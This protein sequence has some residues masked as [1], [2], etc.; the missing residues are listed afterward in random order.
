MKK[1]SDQGLS[2]DSTIRFFEKAPLGYLIL[3]KR[4]MILDVNDKLCQLLNYKKS[5]MISIQLFG[6]IYKEDQ[7][8][9]EDNYKSFFREPEGQKLKLRLLQ[10]D[11]TLFYAELV[12]SKDEI[13]SLKGKNRDVLLVNVIDNTKEQEQ[14]QEIKSNKR[15]FEVLFNQSVVGIATMKPDGTIIEL[16]ERFAG[17]IG[18]QQEELTGR[19]FREITYEKDMKLEEQYLSEVIAGERNSFE[20]EK[21]YIHKDGHLVWIKLYSN[22]VRDNSGNSLYAIASITDISQEKQREGQREL[23]EKLKAAEALL[24]ESNDRYQLLSEVTFEGILIH[25]MGTAI[26]ANS[27]L[28]AMTGLKR[29]NIPDF[30]IFD[31]ISASDQ[32]EVQKHLLQSESEPY[33][34]NLLRQDGSIFLVEIEAR[35]MEYRGEQ[36]RIA[37]IRDISEK[38]KM[39]EQLAM[40]EHKFRFYIENAPNGF[41]AIDKQGDYL[42]VNKAFCEITGY[43]ETEL[44]DMGL[45]DIMHPSIIKQELEQFDNLNKNGTSSSLITFIRKDGEERVWNEIGKKL[46]D[47]RYIAFT[48][49]VTEQIKAQERVKR[50][51]Q[52]LKF[53]IEQMPIAVMITGVPGISKPLF[54]QLAIDLVRFTPN[55]IGETILPDNHKILPMLYPDRRQI[56]VKDLPL[57]KAISQ[58]ISTHNQDIIIPH[59]DGDHWISTSAEP[60]RDEQGNIIAGIVVFPEI[61]ARKKLETK[62]RENQRLLNEVE[63]LARIGGWEIDVITGES[64]WTKGTFD[65]ME[66][67]YSDHIPGMHEHVDYYM[68]EYRE[69]IN[70]K[71]AD[72]INNGIPLECEAEFVTEQGNIKWGK[73]LGVREMKDGKCLRI[74]GTFQDITQQKQLEKEIRS[75][76]AQME[77]ILNNTN[78][79]ILLG[80]KDGKPVYYNSAYRQVMEAALGLEVKQ[81]DPLHTHLNSEKEKAYWEGLHKRVLSGESFMAQYSLPYLDGKIHYLELSYSPVIE[82]G[83]ISG[84][85]EITRDITEGKLS[86]LELIE[87]EEKYRFLAETLQN[88]IIMHDLQGKILYVNQYSIDYFGKSKKEL[89]GSS[90]DQF[91]TM[92]DQVERA[93]IINDMVE[94]G[95]IKHLSGFI[96]FIKANGETRVL[97]ISTSPIFKDQTLINFLLIARDVTDRLQAEAELAEYREHLEQLVNERTKEL[98]K[99]KAELERI[100]KLFVG[101]EFRIKEL[102]DKVKSLK[103]KLIA[104]GVKLEDDDQFLH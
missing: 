90:I 8:K 92:K 49:D 89:T 1:N 72:L 22:I 4:G 102:R 25:K 84:F 5:E 79:F 57:S 100:N 83:K 60:I 97:E 31:I 11:D 91:L 81:G 19:N 26:D 34:I 33:R 85:S 95:E 20:L 68:F 69:M 59:P 87:S 13:S 58:G 53:A 78:D 24:L 54:N 40:S 43:S 94:S 63:K 7:R 14:N 50:S 32:A 23:I 39:E 17:I 104:H 48:Q 74:Y 21:R 96:D 55:A 6:F 88:I 67:P 76:T 46:T 44:L 52:L 64:I 80:D 37:A 47:G 29:E 73:T 16:N 65:I 12:G 3:D 27:S 42:E 38:V 93:A 82:N 41:F 9:Y 30:N 77:S 61:T 101:R 86:E 71:I 28:L 103:N 35:S 18:Y 99:Q 10:K 75:K 51:E 66:I 15:R 70:Q 62:L 56:D 98:E 2:I 45:P 36:I